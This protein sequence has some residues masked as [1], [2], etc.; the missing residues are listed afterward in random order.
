MTILESVVQQGSILESNV[1]EL[2]VLQSDVVYAIGKQGPAGPQGPSGGSAVTFP[3]GEVIAPARVVIIEG[4]EAFHFQPGN[5]AHQGRAYGISTASAAIGADTAIQIGGEI[6]HA[7]F[8]FSADRM[9]Y[10]FN[11]GIIVDTVPSLALIQL[12]GISS[13]N[14]KMRIDFSISIK[15]A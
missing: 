6:E 2:T 3:A 14:N 9:L 15:K 10:V 12:A 11:N 7:S 5:V 1:V 13:E 8:S 4:G